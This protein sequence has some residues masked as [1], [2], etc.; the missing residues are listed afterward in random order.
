MNEN[1]MNRKLKWR[2]NRH[3]SE[4]HSIQK[5]KKEKRKKKYKKGSKTVMND[6]KRNE[7]CIKAYAKIKSK[8]NFKVCQIPPPCGLHRSERR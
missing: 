1:K 6:V 3:K 5:N 7:N 8:K 4:V 2:E